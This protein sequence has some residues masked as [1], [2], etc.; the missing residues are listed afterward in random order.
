MYEEQ[1][2]G[3]KFLSGCFFGGVTFIVGMLLFKK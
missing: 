2:K 3:A 1:T